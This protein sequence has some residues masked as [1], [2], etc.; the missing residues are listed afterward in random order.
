M[1]YYVLNVQTP[2]G[3]LKEK[4]NAVLLAMVDFLVSNSGGRISLYNL[5]GSNP[6]TETY[7][8]DLKI[9][10]SNHLYRIESRSSD[11]PHYHSIRNADGTE[12][13][14]RSS[15]D[16]RNQV[17]I[18]FITNNSIV[19]NIWGIVFVWFKCNNDSVYSW[20][21]N[22]GVTNA[23]HHPDTDETYSVTYINYNYTD[24]NDCYKLI[25]CRFINSVN[26]IETFYSESFLR[27]MTGMVNNTIYQ[28]AS[29]NQ[30]YYY[31]QY[32]IG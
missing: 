14:Y 24:I 7:I 15:R 22:Q 27:I 3:T 16:W 10:G 11:Y 20:A 19:I 6:A 12:N 1:A 9:S 28:D 31:G 4:N 25:P 29:G 30:W 5:E 8:A 21:I 13:L 26:K 2:S 18:L 17:L 23:V 32:L